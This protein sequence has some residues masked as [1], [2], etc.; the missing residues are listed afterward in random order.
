M[1]L[2]Q[3]CTEAGCRLGAYFSFVAAESL[4]CSPIRSVSLV[5]RF[6]ASP[7]AGVRAGFLPIVVTTSS[8]ETSSPTF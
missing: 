1:R 4:P 8:S 2:A 5:D 3:A 7:G 6:M